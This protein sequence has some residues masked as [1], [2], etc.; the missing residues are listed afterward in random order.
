MV[1]VAFNAFL[2][3]T[4]SII[5]ITFTA[6]TAFREQV[7]LIRKRMEAIFA[8]FDFFHGSFLSFSLMASAMTYCACEVTELRQ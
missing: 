1:N 5:L 7:M 4:F 3:G 8:E 2:Y 6:M